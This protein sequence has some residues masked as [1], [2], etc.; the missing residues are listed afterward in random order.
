[1]IFW[2]GLVSFFALRYGLK[3]PDLSRFVIIFCHREHIA[4]LV[5]GVVDFIRTGTWSLYQTIIASIL[6]YVLIWVEGTSIGWTAG[7]PGG[8]SVGRTDTRR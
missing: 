5:F 3:R 7:L 6:A 4:L 8:C 1:M 2:A